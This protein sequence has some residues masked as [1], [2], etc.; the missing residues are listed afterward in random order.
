MEVPAI[1]VIPLRIVFG[2][3]FVL[4]MGIAGIGIFIMSI[5]KWIMEG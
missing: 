4:G 3:V 5:A 2:A 1:I